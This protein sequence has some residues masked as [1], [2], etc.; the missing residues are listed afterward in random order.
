M[1]NAM[2]RIV[3]DPGTHYYLVQ[4]R[5]LLFFWFTVGSGQ[6]SL[7]NALVHLNTVLVDDCMDTFKPRYYN[8]NGGPV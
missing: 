5:F 7:E 4:K 8:K 2:Y 6:T 1:L 3:L